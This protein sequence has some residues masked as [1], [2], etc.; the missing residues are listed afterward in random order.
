MQ[1]SHNQAIIFL[2][3]LK[4]L[5]KLIKKKFKCFNGLRIALQI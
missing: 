1:V 5:L 2:L 3:Y 4:N